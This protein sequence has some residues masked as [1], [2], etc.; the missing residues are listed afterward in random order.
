VYE[1]DGDW[2][3]YWLVPYSLP[4]GSSRPMVDAVSFGRSVLGPYRAA[5]QFDRKQRARRSRGGRPW[6]FL[7]ERNAS[8][9]LCHDLLTLRELEVVRHLK[10][11]VCQT[12]KK[13]PCNE[14][15]GV[16]HDYVYVKCFLPPSWRRGT[17]VGFMHILLE[18]GA[19][20][21]S[22]LTGATN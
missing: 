3:G 13:T 2:T 4:Y 19:L 16:C 18:L 6:E 12:P 14:W 11:E 21:L 22:P 20:P 17:H 9:V 8:R 1:S 7:A 10:T 5:L 15:L